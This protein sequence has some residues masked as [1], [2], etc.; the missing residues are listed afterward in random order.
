MISTRDPCPFPIGR[1][2]DKSRTQ[3]AALASVPSWRRPKFGRINVDPA[4]LK[5]VL[6]LIDEISP[7]TFM[8]MKKHR[9]KVLAAKS[10]N[11][12]HAWGIYEPRDLVIFCALRSCPGEAF[13]ERPAWLSAAERVR[14]G[15]TSWSMVFSES[16]I[17]EEQEGET[18]A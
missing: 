17:W 13:F 8:G 3:G 9:R 2:I 14:N 4:T 12:A 18:K 11:K 16:E 6:R 5:E 7:E 10:I 15:L 1:R